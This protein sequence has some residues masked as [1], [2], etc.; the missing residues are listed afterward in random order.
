MV[1]PDP[2]FST[3]AYTPD[4]LIAGDSD[5]VTREVT[6][7]E[8]QAQGALTRGAVLGYFVTDD[9]Y[10]RVHQTGNYTATTA[11][12]I[13]AKDADPSSGDVTALVYVA[14]EINEDRVNLGGTVTAD[15]VRESLQSVGIYLKSPT[16]A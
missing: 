15:D 2:D 12:A 6:L 11:K 7:T 16:S 1:M 9:K 5:L 10:A 3:S 4:R 13:L 8:N 14:G